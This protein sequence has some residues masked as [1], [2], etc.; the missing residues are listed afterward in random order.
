MEDIKTSAF[1]HRHS[2]SVGFKR[3]ASVSMMM[4]ELV[5]AFPEYAGLL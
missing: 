4:E 1:A 3:I 2:P 5:V